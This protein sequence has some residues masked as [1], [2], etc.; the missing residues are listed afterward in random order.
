MAGPLDQFIV[1][2]TVPLHIAGIDVSFTNA[3]AWMLIVT[4]V[5]SLLIWAGL[6]RPS[7]VPGPRPVGGRDDVRDGRRDLGQ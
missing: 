1:T 2:R 6:R 4:G 7:L 3:S 5:A